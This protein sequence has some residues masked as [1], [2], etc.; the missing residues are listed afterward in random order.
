MNCALCRHGNTRLGEVTV[1][2]QREGTTV[3][4]KGVPAGV[5]DNCGESYL[6][7]RVTEKVLARA[8]DAVKSGAEVVIL[9]FAA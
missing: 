4:L 2:F 5:C 1:T 8:E 9:R 7:E 6:A 3:I